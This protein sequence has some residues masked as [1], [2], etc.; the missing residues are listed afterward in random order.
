MLTQKRLKELLNY[1]P[2]TGVFTWRKT[3]GSRGIAGSVA[4]SLRKNGYVSIMVDKT[5][6]YAHRLAWLYVY[7]EMPS[8]EIDHINHSKTDNSISN[9]RCVSHA[10]NGKNTS[11]PSDNKSGAVGVIK[12]KINNKWMAYIN[13][14]GKRI[15]LGRFVEFDKAVAARKDAE[16]KFGFHC[17]HGTPSQKAGGDATSAGT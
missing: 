8:K 9:L 11:I 3:V 4:G 7:G 17:N 15:H 1:D 2:E 13:A 5:S 6:V 14:N 12:D 10:Q 16:L